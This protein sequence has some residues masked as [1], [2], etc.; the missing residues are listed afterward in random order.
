MRQVR[1]F[2]SI[3]AFCA[4]IWVLCYLKMADFGDFQEFFVLPKFWKTKQ[5]YRILSIYGIRLRMRIFVLSIKS[6]FMPLNEPFTCNN[7]NFVIFVL[8][9]F[10]KTLK[11]HR[12]HPIYEIRLRMRIF[13][14]NMKSC[15]MPLNDHFTCKNT[16]FVIFVLQK[17]LKTLKLIEIS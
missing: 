5:I 8:Q 15:F 2:C 7:T 10:L 3:D 4:L 14:L 1:Y 13:V 12:I 6:C 9:I 11:T 16:N 17:F